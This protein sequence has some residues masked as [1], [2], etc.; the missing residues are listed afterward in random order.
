MCLG[1]KNP[2]SF[3]L[4]SVAISIDEVHEYFKAIPAA[5]WKRTLTG[6]R[7]TSLESKDPEN[8]ASSRSKDYLRVWNVKGR[9]IA[10]ALSLA[11]FRALLA[12]DSSG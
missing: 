9:S 2:G 8:R 1:A 5:G 4:I 10:T 3:E 11:N 7:K 6:R 12:R